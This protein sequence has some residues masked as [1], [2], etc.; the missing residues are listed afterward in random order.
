MDLQL[1]PRR[2]SLMTLGKVREMWIVL[3]V[4]TPQS[5]CR[6]F[7]QPIPAGSPSWTSERA[8]MVGASTWCF[9]LDH[10]LPTNA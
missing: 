5:D 6:L 3:N 9:L 4:Y 2:T 1:Q 7:L 8:S 10:F